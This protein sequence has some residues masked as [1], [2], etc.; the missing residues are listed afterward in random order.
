MNGVSTLFYKYPS[1]ENTFENKHF[2]LFVYLNIRL[3]IR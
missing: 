3:K 1:T 2:V